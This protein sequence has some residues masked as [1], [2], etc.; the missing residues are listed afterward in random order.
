MYEANA[1]LNY[2]DK[3]TPSIIIYSIYPSKSPLRVTRVFEIL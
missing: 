2:I 1:N 3:L